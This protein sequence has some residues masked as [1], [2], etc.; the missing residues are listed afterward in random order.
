M[1]SDQHYWTIYLMMFFF[2]FGFSFFYSLKH[3]VFIFSFAFTNTNASSQ[4]LIQKGKKINDRNSIF[5][6]PK[7]VFLSR[8]LFQNTHVEIQSIIRF[9]Y[10]HTFERNIL[11]FIF[12]FDKSHLYAIGPK[13]T[14]KSIYSVVKHREIWINLT[15]TNINAFSYMYGSCWSRQFFCCFPLILFPPFCYSM[16]L[17]SIIVKTGLERALYWFECDV[18]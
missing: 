7:N 9:A 14:I 2:F 6:V 11:M 4:L 15:K 1:Q 10:L 8:K 12:W 16:K 5:V 17:G 13:L 18:H 3:F